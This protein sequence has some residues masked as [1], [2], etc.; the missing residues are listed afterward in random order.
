MLSI[1]SDIS[2]LIILS[3][4]PKTSEASAFASSV[5]PTPVGPTNINEGGLLVLFSPALF[6]LIAR[7]TADTASFWP[8]TL[9]WRLS[10]KD[11]SFW[12]SSSVIF[13]TGIFVQFSITLA[14]SWMVKTTG[15]IRFS[16]ASICSVKEHS[17]VFNS[18]AF[19]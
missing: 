8:I 10:S 4:L 5:L 3:S 2:I 17:W 13:W 11:N 1:Y 7:A 15:F 6:L 16:I 9:L 14:I 19:L 12:V 18:A